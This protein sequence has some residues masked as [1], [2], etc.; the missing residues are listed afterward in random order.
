MTLRPTIRILKG[1]MD[2]RD[3][4]LLKKWIDLNFTTIMASWDEEI[5][6]HDLRQMIKKIPG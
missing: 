6:D 1:D 2:R 5:D 3:F 4:D